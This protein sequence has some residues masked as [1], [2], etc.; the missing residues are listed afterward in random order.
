MKNGPP[1]L[2]EERELLYPPIISVPKWGK[3]TDE[4]RIENSLTF[5]QIKISFPGPKKVVPRTNFQMKSTKIRTRQELDELDQFKVLELDVESIQAS[6]RQDF[7]DENI[8]QL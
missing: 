2:Q 7:K 4:V 8:V 6:K 1:F 3:R 5:L